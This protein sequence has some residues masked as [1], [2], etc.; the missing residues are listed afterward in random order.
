MALG[1]TNGYVDVHSAAILRI[2]TRRWRTALD[3]SRS[4]L[5]VLALLHAL[6]EPPSQDWRVTIE[7]PRWRSDPSTH[8]RP[9][10]ACMED[11][12]DEN[13]PLFPVAV[14]NTRGYESALARSSVLGD[15]HDTPHARRYAVSVSPFVRCSL[16][17]QCCTDSNRSLFFLWTPAFP[18]RYPPPLYTDAT[19]RRARR[20]EAPPEALDADERTRDIKA[21]A[22]FVF[23]EREMVWAMPL[24][25]N[26]TV[27][28]MVRISG[29]V[30]EKTAHVVDV[31]YTGSFTFVMSTTARTTCGDLVTYSCAA[32]LPEITVSHMNSSQSAGNATVNRWIQFGVWHSELRIAASRAR[33]RP[34]IMER[35]DAFLKAHGSVLLIGTAPE[36]AH[37]PR[38]GTWAVPAELL[39]PTSFIQAM[40]DGVRKLQRGPLSGKGLPD[41]V[42]SRPRCFEPSAGSGATKLPASGGWVLSLDVIG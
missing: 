36:H 17:R 20:G 5:V 26:T 42:V 35:N 30:M 2:V 25:C 10:L 3:V 31:H 11:D 9:A 12:E 38:N 14:Q 40:N 22:P 15:A 19:D 37:V 39:D 29:Q 32:L 18:T 23:G 16:T 34:P 8:Q 28:F 1:V 7:C 41:A 33:L 24:S 27:G 6:P 4:P 21:R 13:F